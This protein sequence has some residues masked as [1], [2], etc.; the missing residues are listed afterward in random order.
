MFWGEKQ[1]FHTILTKLINYKNR[2][3]KTRLRLT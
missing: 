2:V 1:K 3:R